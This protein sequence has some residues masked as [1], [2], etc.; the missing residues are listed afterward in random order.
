MKR[1]V[2]AQ[3]PSDA[4]CT[5]GQNNNNKGL[6]RVLKACNDIYQKYTDHISPAPHSARTW[7]LAC[8]WTPSLTSASGSNEDGTCF[9]P[10]FWPCNVNSVNHGTKL[11]W[12]VAFMVWP[13]P[14]KETDSAAV[15]SSHW[16]SDM[17]WLTE[18]NL[19]KKSRLFQFR[20]VVN[21]V[22][23][24]L[25]TTPGT[26]WGLRSA[27]YK[28]V[29]FIRSCYPPTDSVPLIKLVDELPCVTL[30][31]E[32]SGR[33]GICRKLNTLDLFREN[34]VPIPD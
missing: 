12:R 6:Q 33:C 3:K 21:D 22:G 5:I 16:N 9:E 1:A 20:I 2:S 30:H 4:W 24:L 11:T 17:C 31:A 34:T 28:V 14:E 15:D 8:H 23:S 19:D 7:S 10:M 26:A 13:S 18:P 27:V 25:Q 29:I 32:K